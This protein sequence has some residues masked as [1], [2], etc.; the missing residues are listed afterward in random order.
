VDNKLVIW[1][2][3]GETVSSMT[4]IPKPKRRKRTELEKKRARGNVGYKA[5]KLQAMKEGRW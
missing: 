1:P 2:A 4:L 5:R 3:S